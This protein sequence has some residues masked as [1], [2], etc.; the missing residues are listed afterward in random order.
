[1][2]RFSRFTFLTARE[3][4]AEGFKKNGQQIKKKYRFGLFPAGIIVKLRFN[5]TGVL[6][7]ETFF[8]YEGLIEEP[9]A[10]T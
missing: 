1:L 9:P 4:H 6:K 8:V 3:D 2:P 10:K 7:N 5:Q